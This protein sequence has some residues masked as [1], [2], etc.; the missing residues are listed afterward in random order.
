MNEFDFKARPKVSWFT[1]NRQCNFRCP[2]CYGEDTH[3]SSKDTMSLATAKELAQI[4]AEVGVRYINIIGGEPTLW[5]HLFDT[6]IARK[7]V[8]FDDGQGLI[9]HLNGHQIVEEF[10]QLL[11][12][13]SVSCDTCR[14]NRDCRGGCLLNWV[15]YDPSICHAVANK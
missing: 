1:V 5:P 9:D 2:W 6:R 14:W 7:T 8:D 12:F 15:L 3:Y 11:R 10:R 4:T 13:P